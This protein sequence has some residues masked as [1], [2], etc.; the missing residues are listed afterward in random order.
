MEHAQVEVSWLHP[1]EGLSLY[2]T[3]HYILH[4]TLGGLYTLHYTLG[5]LYLLCVWCFMLGIH[6]R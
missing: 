3:L 5:G 1:S 2:K 4:Y 6:S